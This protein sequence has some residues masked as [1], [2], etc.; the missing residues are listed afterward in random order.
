MM[1]H[2]NKIQIMSKKN[3]NKRNNY[4]DETNIFNISQTLSN[5][6]QSI[7]N[8]LNDRHDQPEYASQ[9]D[10]QTFDAFSYGPSNGTYSSN[11]PNNNKNQIRDISYNENY[12]DLSD[13]NSTYGIIPH[14]NI[15]HN[16]MVP[17]FNTRNGYGS[18][19]IMYTKNADYKNDLFTGN[20]TDTKIKKKESGPIFSPSVGAVNIHGT[21]IMSEY[22]RT[23]IIPSRYHQHTLPF[24]QQ[25]VTPGVNIGYESDGKHGFHPMYRTIPKTIDELKVNPKQ[26]YEGRT[27]DG[28][29]GVKRPTEP[30]VISYRPESFYRNNSDDLIPTYYDVD[31]PKSLENYLLSDTNKELTHIEYTG[32]AYNKQDTMEKNIPEYM[33]AKQQES[34]KSVF[35][36]PESLHKFSGSDTKFNSNTESYNTD[37]TLKDINIR[38]PHTGQVTNNN[39][40]YLHSGTPIEITNKDIISNTPIFNQN[41]KSN[42]M[43]ETAH[44]FDVTRTTLKEINSE[45]KLNPNAIDFNKMPRLYNSDDVRS[46]LRET[47]NEPVMA[48][49]YASTP[50]TYSNISDNMHTTTKDC[51]I[52]GD[53]GIFSQINHQNM[54]HT[55]T[56]SDT[57]N[58]TMKEQL[59]YTGGNTVL[60]SQNNKGYLATLT[61]TP[62]ITTKEQ[63][64]YSSGTNSLNPF[65]N[66]GYMTAPDSPNTTLKDELS[67]NQFQYIINPINHK[68]Y[69]AV[70]NETTRPSMR[71]TTVNI[72]YNTHMNNSK[73]GQKSQLLDEYRKTTKEQNIDK[74][75]HHNISNAVENG[76]FQIM[77]PIR[78]TT[79]EMLINK[80]R[81]NNISNTVENGSSQIIDH[82]RTTTKEMLIN[83]HRNNNLKNIGPN[84]SIYRSNKPNKTTIKETIIDSKRNNIGNNLTRSSVRVNDNVRATTKET[85]LDKLLNNNINNGSNKFKLYSDTPLKTT[86]KESII[87]IP[88]KSNISNVSGD[89]GPSHVYNRKPMDITLKDQNIFQT[90]V[91]NMRSNNGIYTNNGDIARTTTKEQNIH[92]PYNNIESK[93]KINMGMID[94]VRT[95]LKESTIDENH[96]GNMSLDINGK[97]NGYLAKNIDI[98]TTTKDSNIICNKRG[99]ATGITKNTPYDSAYN[100]RI[101]DKKEKTQ[102]YRKP[103]DS[104][105]NMGPDAKTINMRMRDDTNENIKPRLGVTNRVN[106]RLKSRLSSKSTI[107]EPDISVNK[108]ISDQLTSNPYYI[109]YVV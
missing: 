12:S 36:L 24:D 29:K 84:K 90:N 68:N 44:N 78:T 3:G 18:N 85:L 64:M 38:N 11:I 49:N 57:P 39:K 88:Y 1:H 73:N 41:I 76:S 101:N 30:E 80:H 89:T 106:D 34:N 32:G 33:R 46:T 47:T 8:I 66:H 83:K 75:S 53:N 70:S 56:L 37:G 87:S 23:R 2:N 102:I 55:A 15:N 6:T 93:T 43:R 50:T 63:T 40:L 14:Y 97:G 22:D 86:N 77:D 52:Y 107:N 67:Q 7:Q 92:I 59:M 35:I 95:T 100:G 62:I 9:F 25:Y 61:D 17:F 96:Y 42:T 72:P 54:G 108:Y 58:V 16:N 4:N 21:P 74:I 104:N 60:N 20:L 28:M 19:D 71:E 48:M 65:N 98:D 81:N 13:N 94:D 109:D 31:G 45:N 105:V 79:K 91:M 69:R 26:T 27:I 82:I 10:N 99:P 5:N 103:T 51:N